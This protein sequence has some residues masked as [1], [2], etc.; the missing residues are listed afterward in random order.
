[1]LN[2]CCHAGQQ[3]LEMPE[4]AIDGVCI[5]FLLLVHRSHVHANTGRNDD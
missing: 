3:L 2:V 4:H 5:E 1:M